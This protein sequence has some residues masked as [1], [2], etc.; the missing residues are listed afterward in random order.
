M[1][2]THSYPSSVLLI[3]SYCALR[4]KD[5]LCVLAH[6]FCVI[7]KSGDKE[8]DRESHR[9]GAVHMATA[10]LGCKGPWLPPGKPILILDARMGL[11]SATSTW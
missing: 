2:S 5:S 1:H 11:K 8:G 6:K 10:R 9:Q 3:V 7:R 4:R